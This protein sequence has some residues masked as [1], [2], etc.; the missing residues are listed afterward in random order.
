MAFDF[1]KEHVFTPKPSSSTL[2]SSAPNISAYS[3][4]RNARKPKQPSAALPP[5]D[6]KTITP[7]YLLHHENHFDP[8]VITPEQM[9][10]KTFG[11]KALETA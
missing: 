9:Q 5:S 1:F 6:K 8:N 4:V 7:D 11:K 2:D 10:Q 3:M